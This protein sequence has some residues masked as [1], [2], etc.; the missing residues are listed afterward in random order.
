M[1]YRTNKD[2]KGSFHV[3]N[4]LKGKHKDIIAEGT[5]QFNMHLR[6]RLFEFECESADIAKQWYECLL[7]HLKIEEKDQEQGQQEE[8]I[9]AKEEKKEEEKKE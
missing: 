8:E 4:L 1:E 6:D 3:S 9:E 7:T 5:C 2:S